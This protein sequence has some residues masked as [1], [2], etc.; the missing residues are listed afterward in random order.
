[1]GGRKGFFV[2]KF[3]SWEE[4]KKKTSTGTKEKTVGGR[5]IGLRRMGSLTCVLGRGGVPGEW[6]GGQSRRRVWRGVRKNEGGGCERV[7]IKGPRFGEKRKTGA[8]QKKGQG[9]GGGESY[10]Q[11]TTDVN[12]AVDEI[13]GN[14]KSCPHQELGE[15]VPWEE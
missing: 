13:D 11:D 15:E 3:T 10:C 6:G 9:G 14:E 4:K 12:R 1:V 2:E 7:S 5:R 8:G